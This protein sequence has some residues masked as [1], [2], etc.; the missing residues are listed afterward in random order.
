[1]SAQI[2]PS[3]AP[4]HS[5]LAYLLISKGP[6]LAQSLRSSFPCGFDGTTMRITYPHVLSGA[7]TPKKCTWARPLGTGSGCPRLLDRA[8]S[9]LSPACSAE[10][11]LVKVSV[12]VRKR[13]GREG[14]RRLGHCSAYLALAFTLPRAS[15]GRM[16]RSQQY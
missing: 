8:R 14:R 7:N 12:C 13:K 16:R 1:V 6:V 3:F 4:A 5:R 2:E 10:T 15:V 9:G 11:H